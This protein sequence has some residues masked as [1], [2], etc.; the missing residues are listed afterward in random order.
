MDWLCVRLQTT[1]R[2]NYLLTERRHLSR[3]QTG[4]RQDHYRWTDAQISDSSVVAPC[5]PDMPFATAC[6]VPVSDTTDCMTTLDNVARLGQRLI[7][8]ASRRTYQPVTLFIHAVSNVT[9]SYIHILAVLLPRDARS[10]KRRIAI[11]TRPS[12]SL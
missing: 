1:D 12:I 2:M 8:R 5:L 11:I 10:A 7:E 3:T 6:T 4:Q 9:H